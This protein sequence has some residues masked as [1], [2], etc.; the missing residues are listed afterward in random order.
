MVLVVLQTSYD[1]I[2]LRRA[3]LELIGELGCP[4]RVGILSLVSWDGKVRRVTYVGTAGKSDCRGSNDR[5]DARLLMDRAI[6]FGDHGSQGLCYRIR[7]IIE[8]E[9]DA[10]FLVG[11]EGVTVVRQGESVHRLVYGVASTHGDQAG[12][13]EVDT[14]CRVEHDVGVRMGQRA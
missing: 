10:R 9:D 8:C 12:R 4:C 13:T 11:V 14:N 1:D 7:T 3:Q 2:A 6:N 5:D